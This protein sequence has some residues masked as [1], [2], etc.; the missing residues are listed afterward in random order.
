VQSG[1]EALRFRVLGPVEASLDGEPLL[2]RAPLQRTLLAALLARSG[3]AVSADALIDAI[4]A[5]QP[6]DQAR[7]ALLVCLHRLRRTLGD[8]QR[9]ALEPAGYR[10]RVTADDFDAA[11]FAE[12]LA[13]ARRERSAK[14]LERSAARY[15]QALHLWRGPA[16]ADMADFSLIATEAARL[17]DDRLRARQ[18][19]L[20]VRL[21]LGSHDA[22]LGDLEALAR[23]HPFRERLIALRMLALHRAGRQAEALEV[24]RESRKALAGELGVDPGRLVQRMH[25]AVLRNDD[26]LASVA[27]ESLDG[28]WVPLAGPKIEAAAVPR[29][30]PADVIGFTG[31]DGELRELE[32]ARVGDADDGLPASPVVVISGM[33]GVGKTASAVHWA[34]RIADDYPDGQLFL[35]LRGYSA[36]P[37]LQPIGALTAMLRALGL[38]SGQVPAETD[39]AAAR[40]RTETA[41]KRMLILLDNAESAEQVLPLLP[42][43]SRS[44]VIV[45]SRNRLDELLTGHGAFRLDLAPLT[46]DEATRLLKAL[47]R[48]PRSSDRPELDELA[49]SSGYLPL[50]LRLAAANRTGTHPAAPVD[51]GPHA[52]LKATF[53]GSYRTLP[54]DARRMLRL[55][56]VAPVRSLAIEAAAVLAD[57]S[58]AA[59]ERAVEQLVHAHMVNRDGRGRL[60]LHDLIR[61]YAEDLTG[62]DDPVSAAALDRLFGWYLDTALAACRARY[63]G[64]ARLSDHDRDGDLPSLGDAAQAARWLD[65]ERENLVAVARYVGERGHGSVAWRLADALRSHGWAAMS[66]PDFLALGRA[67]LQGAHSD[68]S[69]PGAAVAE[70]CMTTAYFKARDFSDAVRHA[71]R[72]IERARRIGWDEGQ[73]SAHHTMMLACWQIGRLRVS[74]EHGEAALAMNRAGG[75]LRA[76]TVNLGALGGIHVALGELHHAL[77]LREEACR[78]AE[79][80]GDVRIQAMRLGRLA[81]TALDLG[82][83]GAAQEYLNRAVDIEVNVLKGP[84][85]AATADIAAELSSVLGKHDDALVYA[86]TVLR[87]AER[88]YDR[89]NEADGLITVAAVLNRL[90]R[91]AEAVAA[92]AQALR[93]AEVDLTGLRIKALIERA[94][95]RI[96]LGEPDAATADADAAL[97]MARAGEY[98]IDEGM[99][100]NLLAEA[101]LHRGEAGGAR[102]LAGQARDNHRTTGHC[103]GQ[104]WSLWIMGSAARLG[105]DTVAAERYW[106]EVEEIYAAMGAPVPSRFT[107]SSA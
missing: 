66:A 74:L 39:E 76:A 36:L 33:A 8:P 77:R 41:G 35:N 62:A 99:A 81:S 20:E 70:L 14:R 65:D 87:D 102:E 86:E 71:E 32:S 105:G 31:R 101:R 49:R 59:T 60:Y 88:Q 67:A 27:T 73:A 16:Y 54:E 79:E 7:K 104:S 64:Y 84:L 5:E 55:F 1:P 85:S 10:I 56:G 47:L 52:A 23:A 29:E 50:A 95:G 42:G 90:G 72:A 57:M 53:D 9:I 46:P 26:Q 106:R 83:V 94:I 6:P 37:A 34:H 98:R 68:G 58:T 82:Q 4:W 25:E 38:E 19:L 75:R 22:A 15:E 3:R 61:D 78:L 21:D 43:G 97:S 100:L 103:T 13:A 92:A 63:P 91:H 28:T 69:A 96:G 48:I 51:G 11:A 40:L 12:H 24:Y 30:L 2:L 80:S 93:I 45:T 89:A 17:D 44:L 18:E 107:M